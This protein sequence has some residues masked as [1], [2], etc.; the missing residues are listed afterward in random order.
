MYALTLSVVLMQRIGGIK[1][2]SRRFALTGVALAALALS[3]CSQ[4]QSTKNEQDLNWS[5]GGEITTM[6]PSKATDVVSFTQMINSMEGLYR[7]VKQGQEPGLATSA[8]VS[9]DGLTYVFKLRKSKWNDGTPVTAKDFVYSW[10]RTVNPKT[11]AEYAYLFS[12]IKNADAIQNGKKPVSSLGIKAVG[13]YQL[14]VTLEKRMAY[15]KDLMAFPVFFPQEEQAVRKYGDKYGTASKYMAYNGPFLQKGWSGSNL[16]WKLVKNPD[17][18]DKDQV[19]LDQISFTVNKTAST[20]YNLY[21]S[22]KIDALGLDSN[23]TKQFK[24]KSGYYSLANGGTYYLEL[25]E[26]NPNLA[27]SNIRKAISLAINREDLVRILGGNNQAAS[28][29]TAKGLTSVKGQD[30]TS[31]ISPSA[32]KLYKY[33]PSLAKEYWQKGLSELGKSGMTLNLLTSDSDS[34]KKTGEALQSMLETKLPGLKITVTSVPFKTRLA[35]RESGKFQLCG[36]DWIAD[37]GDPISFL[38]LLTSSNASNYGSWKNSRYDQLI[39]ASK[40]T[41]DQ[42]ARMKDMSEAESILLSDAGVVPIYYEDDAWLIRPSVKGWVCNRSE[43]NFKKAYV[44]K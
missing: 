6:D 44:G 39:A 41:N 19:K 29:Y 16:S 37:F 27:S 30:Y 21:E 33:Q 26:K 32:K 40:D 10:R 15:F 3:A 17:Y 42:A 7:N 24:G 25:N 35:R 34:A 11:E 23:L 12:G 14:V 5:V 9:K 13:K 1:M 18:W 36:S 4:K 22:K 20:A 31:L 2:S 28:T 43:W 38:E 8:K